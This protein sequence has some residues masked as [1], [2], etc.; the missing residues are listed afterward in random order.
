MKIEILK[1]DDPAGD[2][3]IYLPGKNRP[4]RNYRAN[5]TGL[6][7]FTE[8]DIENL[9]QNKY[10]DF[11]KGKSFTFEVTKKHLQ[12]ITGERLPQNKIELEMY[13]D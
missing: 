6:H 2:Y 5:I 3:E 4:E 9:L 12:L 13:P 1:T 11:E 7:E 10:S 8:Q